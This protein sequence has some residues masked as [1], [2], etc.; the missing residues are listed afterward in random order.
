MT[1]DQQVINNKKGYTQLIKEEMPNK[2]MDMN[3]DGG[4]QTGVYLLCLLGQFV[5][6]LFLSQQTRELGI[7]HSDRYHKNLG[8]NS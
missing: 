6:K 2:T 7:Y 1:H 8:Q 5:S 3:R 4:T